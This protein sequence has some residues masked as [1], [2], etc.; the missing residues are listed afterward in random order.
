[1]CR[2]FQL[3]FFRSEKLRGFGQQL[4]RMAKLEAMR[5]PR[6]S[7]LLKLISEAD[8]NVPLVSIVFL[9]IGR[10]EGM[11]SATCSHGEARSDAQSASVALAETDQRSRSKCAVGFNCVSSDRKS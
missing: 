10:V 9:Q 11:R 5:N 8:Q 6:A 2:W 7:L 3:C 4:V 1:M